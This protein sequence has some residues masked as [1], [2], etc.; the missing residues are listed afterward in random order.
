MKLYV[1]PQ[2]RRL[3]KGIATGTTTTMIVVS[4]NGFVKVDMLVEVD[5]MPQYL[6][7]HT[8][9]IPSLYRASRVQIQIRTEQYLSQRS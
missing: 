8:E 7:A 4:R 9:L 5:F 3:S 1:L 2:P 6:L